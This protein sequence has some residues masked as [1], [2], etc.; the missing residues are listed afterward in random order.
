MM[1]TTMEVNSSNTLD[2]ESTNSRR[3]SRSDTPMIRTYKLRD[4]E[5]FL[6][7]PD[8]LKS[9]RHQKVGG[10]DM[11]PAH[12]G[13]LAGSLPTRMLTADKRLVLVGAD[14]TGRPKLIPKP[15]LLE[16]LERSLEDELRRLN[17]T[18]VKPNELRF[19]I[20]R[21]VFEILTEYFPA[22]NF[23]LTS[24]K[25]EYDMVLNLQRLEISKLIPLQHEL[26]LL[27]EHYEEETIDQEQSENEEITRLKEDIRKRRE[28]IEKVKQEK[29]ELQREV[30]RL[31]GL[32]GQEYE[33]CRDETDARKLLAQEIAQVRYQ[34]EDLPVHYK[35]VFMGARSSTFGLM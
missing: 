23:V 20:Y 25:N 1:E 10:L 28:Q 27:S 5:Y 4:R 7:L 18:E 19:Q 13:C 31:Q 22:Y 2:V 35:K 16:Q 12:A 9:K 14:D 8:T 15:Q 30:E 3:R 32:L 17:L 33:K 26:V 29:I 24:I 11:W 6:P 21:Q 34:P